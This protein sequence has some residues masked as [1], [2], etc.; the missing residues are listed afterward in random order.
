MRVKSSSLLVSVG[1][2]L[3]GFA[4]VGYADYDVEATGGYADTAYDATQECESAKTN[5]VNACTA[6]GG[7]ITWQDAC[8]DNCTEYSS[9]W[10]CTASGTCS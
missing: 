2:S 10:I 3:L 1:T 4:T 9:G 7:T 6:E 5:L 8:S